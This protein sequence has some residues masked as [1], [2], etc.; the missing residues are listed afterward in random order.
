MA[1]AF[2]RTIAWLLRTQALL[3]AGAAA[4]AV[5]L[6]GVGWSLAVIAGGA[7]GI[8]LTAVAALRAGA[9]TASPEAIAGAFFRAMALKLMLA[10]VIFV[11]VAVWFP[12]WFG[13]ILAGYVVTLLAYWL[14]LWRLARL[15]GPDRRK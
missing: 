15:P 1:G 2:A 12:A 9:T 7:A 10:V 4:L 11:A 13:A 3:V 14:A 5:P 8:A 6:A